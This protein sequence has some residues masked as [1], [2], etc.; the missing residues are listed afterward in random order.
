MSFCVY[1]IL[2]LLLDFSFGIFFLNRLNFIVT[3]TM[4]HTTQDI[5]H[6]YVLESLACV[7]KT[8]YMHSIQFQR[9]NVWWV[10]AMEKGVDGYNRSESKR[11]MLNAF[12]C[13]SI[14]Q[15]DT[16][17]VRYIVELV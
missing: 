6:I 9:Y 4:Q 17:Y 14:E 11:E 1:Y 5:I 2:Q 12:A 15:D 8:T 13:L 16:I 3:Q 10:K 7:N